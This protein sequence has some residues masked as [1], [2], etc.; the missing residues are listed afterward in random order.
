M[1]VLPLLTAGPP[2]LPGTVGFT[3]MSKFASRRVLANPTLARAGPAPAGVGVRLLA[4]AGGPSRSSPK[5]V[6]VPAQSDQSDHSTRRVIA[7]SVYR[8]AMCRGSSRPRA[9]T[10][11]AFGPPASS[12]S[13]VG[14]PHWW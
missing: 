3:R 1:R 7:R 4:Q 11:A 10:H 13:T 5:G 6:R 2:R 9:A 14:C 8:S 12:S